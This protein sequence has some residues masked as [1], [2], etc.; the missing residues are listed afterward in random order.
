MI[1]SGDSSPDNLYI[2]NKETKKTT[3]FLRIECNDNEDQKSN[4]S[5]EFINRNLEKINYGTIG[6]S[7]S[8]LSNS[9]KLYN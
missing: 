6:L 2:P 5:L 8:N 4:D 1:E 3:H 7:H 9:F